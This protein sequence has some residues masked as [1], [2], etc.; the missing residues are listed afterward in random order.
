M[1][2]VAAALLLWKSRSECSIV[3][4]HVS[5]FCRCVKRVGACIYEKVGKI[6]GMGEAAGKIVIFIPNAFFFR[7]G[8]SRV[9]VHQNHSSSQPSIFLVCRSVHLLLQPF[10]HPFLW[11]EGHVSLWPW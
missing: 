3:F 11:P 9:T 2:P 6:I 8:E 5:V 10:I 4:V 1:V 7:T